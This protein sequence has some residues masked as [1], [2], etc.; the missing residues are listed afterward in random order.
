LNPVPKEE[1]NGL[2]FRDKFFSFYSWVLERVNDA[3]RDKCE[4]AQAVRAHVEFEVL[5]DTAPIK[6]D[7]SPT[8]NTAGGEAIYQQLLEEEEKEG[9]PA[10]AASV[11]KNEG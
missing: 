3:G 6:A 11:T 2:R 9:T 8:S 4:L 7:D 5:R 1:F 10:N